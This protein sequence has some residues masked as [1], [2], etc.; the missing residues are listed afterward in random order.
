MTPALARGI[1][2]GMLLVAPFWITVIHFGLGLYVL[3][4][5]LVGIG[6]WLDRLDASNNDKSGP[7]DPEATPRKTPSSGP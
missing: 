3:A 7:E 2:F 5:C 6:Y 1:A 4:A